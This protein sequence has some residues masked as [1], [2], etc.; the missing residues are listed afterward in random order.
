MAIRARYKGDGSEFHAGIPARSLDEEEYQALDTEQRKLVRESPLYDVK[1]DAQM[2]GERSE[3][4]SSSPT[5]TPKEPA[6]GTNP[7]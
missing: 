1:T 3:P 2:G 7:S 5:P 6:P 4:A